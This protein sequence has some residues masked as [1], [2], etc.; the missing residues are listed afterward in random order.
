[1]VATVIVVTTGLRGGMVAAVCVVVIARDAQSATVLLHQHHT[2]PH[3]PPNKTVATPA[4]EGVVITG[5]AMVTSVAHWR[6]FMGVTVRVVTL[7]APL[8]LPVHL[9]QPRYLRE[10][11]ASQEDAQDAVVTTGYLVGTAAEYLKGSIDAIA[12]VVNVETLTTCL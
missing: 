10:Q 9:H 3:L 8:L 4:T 1:M 11:H 12:Q 7:A 6:M 2:H 5:S